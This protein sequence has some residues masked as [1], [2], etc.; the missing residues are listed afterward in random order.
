MR[1]YYSG[2]NALGRQWVKKVVEWRCP[3]CGSKAVETARKPDSCDDG[4]TYCD[5]G[6]TSA[7]EHSPWACLTCGHTGGGY[8]YVWSNVTL[9]NDAGTSLYEGFSEAELQADKFLTTQLEKRTV[10]PP[11]FVDLSEDLSEGGQSVWHP[12]GPWGTS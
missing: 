9:P 12:E 3:K 1:R 2:W 11:V 5:G 8:T 6:P 10:F 4:P 7:D